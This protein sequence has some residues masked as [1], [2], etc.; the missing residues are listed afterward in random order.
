VNRRWFVAVAL[1]ALAA[2]AQGQY[3]EDSVDVWSA[4]V[5]SMAYNPTADV[6][7]GT[8][9]DGL[10]AL[11]CESN[12]VLRRIYRGEA[13]SVQYDSIDNKVYFTQRLSEGTDSVIV[14][15]GTTHRE[16]GAIPLLWATWSVWDAV[17][18]RLYVSC[19]EEDRV[20]VIDCR[21]DTVL[22]HIPVGSGPLKMTL[23]SP[24][25]KLYV[26]NSNSETISIID[27][28]TNQ[29][30]TTIPVG[31]VPGSGCYNAVADKYYCGVPGA[32]F[33]IDGLGD[34]V[35]AYLPLN[36]GQVSTMLSVEAHSLV[37]AGGSTGQGDSIFVVDATSD[38]VI[39]ALPAGRQPEALA[40]SSATDLVYCAEGG[41]NA[42]S[43]I[44]ADGTRVVESVAVSDFPS[45]LMFCP[46][47]GRV[48]V[49]HTNTSMVYLV[50]DTCS[51]VVEAP[52]EPVQDSPGR[53]SVVR[54]AAWASIGEAGIL[55]DAAGRRVAEVGPGRARPN[56]APGVYFV[57]EAQAQAQAQ[58]R[59]VRKIVILN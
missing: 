14:V 17:T 2:S 16:I 10:F 30:L 32:V 13:I 53:A 51:G 28:N 7:Y 3:V 45:S 37:M 47:H 59:T 34:T 23:N 42:L 33:V 15:S 43:V 20:S 5:G 11:S 31:N 54:R 27:L 52:S 8:M 58:A 39:R 38:S 50:R 6:I 46:P 48:Y 40:W 9:G 4:A 44:R 35:V 55:V 19:V 24:R 41:S 57:R 18:N 56:L 1:L 12:V 49:G 26:M 36:T 22:C 29:V 25:R 21:A